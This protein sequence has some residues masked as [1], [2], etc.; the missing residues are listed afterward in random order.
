MRLLFSIILLIICMGIAQGTYQILGGPSNLS[1]SQSLALI[2]GITVWF[3]GQH[4]IL[5]IKK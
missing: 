5:K 1:W 2:V 4:F 3:I